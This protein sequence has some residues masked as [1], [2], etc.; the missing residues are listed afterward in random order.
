V[1]VGLAGEWQERRDARAD[2]LLARVGLA[3][4]RDAYPR[5]I[6]GG[7]QQ[8]VALCAA[9]ARRPHLLIAD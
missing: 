1:Q 4:R 8:R 7:E 2:E 5:E 3:A 9:L 6:S